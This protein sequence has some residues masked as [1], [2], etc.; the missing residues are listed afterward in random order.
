MLDKRMNYSCGY[1]ENTNSLEDAQELIK[2]CNKIPSKV[3]L[4]EYNKVKN[5]PYEK[6]T[7]I[8]TNMFLELLEKNKILVKLRRSRGEDID[9]A[10]GQLATQIKS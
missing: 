2:F 3:N 6:S 10:C 7:D 5:T 9:A 4:I 1:W 8:T